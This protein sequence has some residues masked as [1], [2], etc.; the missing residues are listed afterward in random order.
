MEYVFKIIQSFIRLFLAFEIEREKVELDLSW[1][2]KSRQLDVWREGIDI[3]KKRFDLGFSESRSLYHPPGI[4]FFLERHESRHDLVFEHGLDLMGWTWKKYE[5][6]FA[7]RHPQPWGR[8]VCVFENFGTFDD[9]GLFFIHRRHLDSSAIE[10][11][12]YLFKDLLFEYELFSEYGRNDLAGA[13]V[14]GGAESADEK[15]YVRT[16]ETAADAI[17]KIIPPV[18][19]DGLEIDYQSQVI[20]T[21]SDE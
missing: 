9:I 18:S 14:F 3:R 8:S 2:G 16:D 11:M 15:D 1:I 4:E 17:S 20:H 13:V 12:L 21:L 6:F 19:D 5:N 10:S 7:R